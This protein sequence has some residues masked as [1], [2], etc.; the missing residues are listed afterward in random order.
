M[1]GTHPQARRLGAAAV[2]PENTF[3]PED[4]TAVGVR[5]P[6]EM[7]SYTITITPGGVTQASAVLTVHV[8]SSERRVTE[9]SIRLGTS[10]KPLPDELA[11]FDFRPILGTVVLL[12]RG[13]L[14]DHFLSLA[15][16]SDLSASSAESHGPGSG[17]H[18]SQ[19]NPSSPG[20]PRTRSRQKPS[21][22]DQTTTANRTP[23]GSAPPAKTKN[24]W[25]DM[26]SDLAVIYWRKETIAK[27][28]NHYSV[29]R[30]IAQRWIKLL[31][32][33]G[34]VPNPWRPASS[35]DRDHPVGQGSGSQ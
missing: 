31:R 26:P 34:T 13:Q 35:H 10:K 23:R 8:D 21:P 1:D 11:T 27:V 2:C 24:Q 4:A 29:P 33:G 22:A 9:I 7:T 19:P 5:R 18:S 3:S 28:A 16:E 15:G 20:G 32:Q 14:P 25:E 17:V 6:F 30:H 12:S